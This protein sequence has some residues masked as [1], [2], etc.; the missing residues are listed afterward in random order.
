MTILLAK[1]LVYSNRF[2]LGSVTF[3][4][5]YNLNLACEMEKCNPLQYWHIAAAFRA[6][7]RTKIAGNESRE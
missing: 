7:L 1:D 3:I 5:M 2:S 4:V 6:D